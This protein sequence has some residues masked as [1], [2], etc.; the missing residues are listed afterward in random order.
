MIIGGVA[1]LADFGEKATRA[2]EG[3]KEG[4]P[5]LEPS[6]QRPPAASTSTRCRNGAYRTSA[7]GAPTVVL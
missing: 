2:H 7:S 6:R 3:K 1:R 5:H 4:I